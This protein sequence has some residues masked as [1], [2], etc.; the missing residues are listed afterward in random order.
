MT[1]VA[2]KVFKTVN[3]AEVPTYGTDKSAGFDLALVDD[4]IVPPGQHL[5]ARTGLVIQAPVGHMLM[6]V[7]RSSTWKNYRIMLGNT[8]GIVDEDF[9]GP[10]DEL[11]LNLYN[12]GQFAQH[13]SKGSRL[14]Q[15]IFVPVTRGEFVVQDEPIAENRGGW[16]STGL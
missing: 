7:P 11:M 2:V 13:I 9:C 6:I 14:A 4:V 16:G 8:V 15:G 12:A 10:K 3:A 1:A 5:M